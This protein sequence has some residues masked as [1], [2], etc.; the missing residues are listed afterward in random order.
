MVSR[1]LKLFYNN[2]KNNN[3]DATYVS[4][5]SSLNHKTVMTQKRRQKCYPNNLIPLKKLEQ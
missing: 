5:V 1:I 4:E 3:T 2:I